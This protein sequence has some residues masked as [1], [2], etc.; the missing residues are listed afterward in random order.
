MNELVGGVE[1]CN[2]AQEDVRAPG[3]INFGPQDQEHVSGYNLEDNLFFSR[4]IE[5]LTHRYS[6]LY[7]PSAGIHVALSSMQ[8]S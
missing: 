5:V 1:E 7:K 8:H 4:F 6:F 3:G 2:K